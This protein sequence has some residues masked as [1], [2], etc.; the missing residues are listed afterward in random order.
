MTQYADSSQYAGFGK[1]FL[2]V[3]LDGVILGIIN[4]LLTAV[5]GGILGKSG[6]AIASLALILITW[7]YYAIQ[8]SSAK[9]ATIG[10]QALGIVVTDLDGKRIDFVKAT[11]RH[12]SKYISTIILMIGYLMALFTEKK[13]DLHDMTAGT[14]VV[15]RR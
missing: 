14:L 4:I 5:V 10:K 6:Q 13:Q 7:L 9:Q 8:E 12:F 3:L 2:A 1:R 15:N 11:I